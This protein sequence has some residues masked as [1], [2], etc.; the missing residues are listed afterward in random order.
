MT[1]CIFG[2][3]GRTGKEVLQYALGENHDVVA[4]VFHA[5]P[6]GYFARGVVVREVDIRNYD[7]V[8]DVLHD[9]GAVI[10]V[11]GHIR[12]SHP[13]MQTDGMKNIVRAM[14]ELGVKRIL[15]LTGTG[16]RAEG[17]TPSR[18]DRILNVLVERIDPDRIHDGRKHVEVLKAS[19]LDWTVV[20]VLKLSSSGRDVT[21]YRLTPGGPAE[22]MTSR[23]KVAKIL[24]D[25]VPDTQ[26][27]R[28]LPV[29]SG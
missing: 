2:A 19:S 1:L 8:K 20:R 16:A 14:E 7:S 17:D 26:Y 29:V 23:K 27:V 28:M 3:D 4:C 13:R 9:C 6:D 21:G 15:S 10:S 11:V 12:G 25:L 18:I 5:V 22:L 24:V